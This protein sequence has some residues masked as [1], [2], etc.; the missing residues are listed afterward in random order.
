MAGVV[1]CDDSGQKVVFGVYKSHR[2][3]VA[4]DEEVAAARNGVR[5]KIG[6]RRVGDDSHAYL[7]RGGVPPERD[8]LA[9]RV[10]HLDKLARSGL[11]AFDSAREHPRMPLQDAPLAPFP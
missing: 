1:V 10:A 2:V 9:I 4:V 7:R 11:A 6:D 3:R 5:D 8:L